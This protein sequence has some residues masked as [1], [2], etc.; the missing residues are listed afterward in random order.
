MAV[1]R[2]DAPR[3]ELDQLLEKVRAQRTLPPPSERREIREGA[4]VSQRELARALGFS[5]TAIQR[6]EAGATPRRHLQ[7]YATALQSLREVSG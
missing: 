2:T 6:W 5:W 4:A 7:E 1:T 3:Q